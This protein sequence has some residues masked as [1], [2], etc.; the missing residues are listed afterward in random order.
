[1]NIRAAK[2]AGAMASAI[3]L[4]LPFVSAHAQSHLLMSQQ[5]APN[6]RV[7]QIAANVYAFI[8]NNTTHFWEDGNTTVII[9]DKGVVVV[10]A[11]STYLSEEHLAEIRKLTDKPVIYLINT[12][13]HKDHVFGNHVYRDA[14]P[15]IEIIAQEFTKKASDE[16]NP[17]KLEEY[18]RGQSGEAILDMVR[19]QAEMGVDE[20]GKSMTGY[21]LVHA[22]MDYPEY[23]AG[24]QAAQRTVYVGPNKTFK[25]SMTLT[26]GSTI[27]QLMHFEGHTAGDAVVFLPKQNI[28]VTGDLV[29]GPI[30]YVGPTTLLPQWIASLQSLIAM[31]ASAIIPG[32]GEV[33]FD[34]S[35]MQ[36]EHDLVASVTEQAANAVASHQS[37]DAFKQALDLKSFENR[38]VDNDAENQ[39]GWDHY[40]YEGLVERAY[41]IE[42][43]KP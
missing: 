21:D 31:H 18:F 11:P 20:N 6:F 37:L 26:F 12:H 3:W 2:L 10:D 32:H 30:P 15:H 34:S 4:L 41:A 16:R 29:M 35:F 19:R 24:Y 39:W 14:F 8:S 23:L 22:K 36:L 40:T 7:E 1:M 27:I 42:S 28:L 25:D 9:T 17:A 33:E 5:L 43:G 13:W 38:M